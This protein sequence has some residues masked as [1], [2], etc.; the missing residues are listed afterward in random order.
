MSDLLHFR[1]RLVW[2]GPCKFPYLRINSGKV[3]TRV[4][5]VVE[6]G[7]DRRRARIRFTTACHIGWYDDH[8]GLR[9][10]REDDLPRDP[11]DYC[12][13]CFGTTVPREFRVRLPASVSEVAA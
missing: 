3:H 5:V 11:A 2:S 13:N 8:K 9:L 6:Y 1:D 12:L 7:K 4:R 10:L